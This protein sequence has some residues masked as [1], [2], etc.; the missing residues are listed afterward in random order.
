[1]S[2]PLKCRHVASVPGVTYF[3]PAGIPLRLLQE[4]C[5]NVEEAESLRLKDIEG[6]EQ[7]QAA[8]KMKVSRPTFQRVLSAARKKLA[9][10][11]L[12]GKAIRIEGGHFELRN[13]ITEDKVNLKQAQEDYMKI[14]VVSDDGISVSQHFGR[15][16]VYVVATVENGKIT[17]EESRDKMGHHH[18]AA[19]EGHGSHAGPHG[20]DAESQSR[21]G[22]MASAIQDCQVLIAGGMGMGAYDSMKSY[23]IQPVVTNVSTID[24]AIRLYIE[25]KLPN[26]M[27]RLH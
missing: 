9:D 12:N 27:D 4:V 20:Y 7:K 5:L 1:M 16:T 3:K 10:A 15:A 18:F 26:L 8:E 17:H 21:H 22:K 23:N 11:L 25:G 24:E 6:L 2:R 14:A 19:A 13:I